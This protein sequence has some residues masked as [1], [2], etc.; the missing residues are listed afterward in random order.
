MFVVL[1]LNLQAYSKDETVNLP[2]HSTFQH[3]FVEFLVFNKFEMTLNFV[4]YFFVTFQILCP[5]QSSQTL[6]EF[7]NKFPLKILR[8]RKVEQKFNGSE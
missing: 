6:W 3:H 7:L 5:A 8:E 4:W 1:S 2:D